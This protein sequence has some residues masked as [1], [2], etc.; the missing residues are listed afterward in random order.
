MIVVY[1]LTW[2][3]TSG[4]RFDLIN[5]VKYQLKFTCRNSRNMLLQIDFEYYR[6]CKYR[7]PYINI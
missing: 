4:V 1:S 2:K 3:I 5:W 7:L 6:Y